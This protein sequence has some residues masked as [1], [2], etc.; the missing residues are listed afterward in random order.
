MKNVVCVFV[1]I[2]SFTGSIACA[3]IN[4][5]VRPSAIATKAHSM[6]V[7]TCEPDDPNACGMHRRW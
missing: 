3:Q 6:P 4:N 7:P 5:D 2:L 1:F